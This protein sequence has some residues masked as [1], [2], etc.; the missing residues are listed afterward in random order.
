M[1]EEGESIQDSDS[2]RERSIDFTDVRIPDHVY[3]DNRLHG[4]EEKLDY[5]NVLNK[6]IGLNCIHNTRRH[7]TSHKQYLSP[8]PLPS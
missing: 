1:K 6:R 4:P 7:D 3:Q 8:Q 2:V 5:F